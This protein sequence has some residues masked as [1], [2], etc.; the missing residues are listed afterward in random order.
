MNRQPSPLIGAFARLVIAEVVTDTPGYEHETESA[1]CPKPKLCTEGK[2]RILEHSTVQDDDTRRR[3]QLYSDSHELTFINVLPYTLRA[4]S[5]FYF[6]Q[7]AEGDW[8]PVSPAIPIATRVRGIV[9]C[10]AAPGSKIT[11]TDLVGIN[12]SVDPLTKRI[13][14]ENVHGWEAFAGSAVKAE[15]CEDSESWETYQITCGD[16]YSGSCFDDSDADSDSDSC[17]DY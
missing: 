16:D 9:K 17:D 3:V 6:I 7:L 14:A 1:A 8:L 10:D 13:E 4:K 2:A 12:G 15:Y 11:I 5:V